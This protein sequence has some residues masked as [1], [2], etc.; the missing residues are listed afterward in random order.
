[1]LKKLIF[2][3]LGYT[4]IHSSVFAESRN[5]S[6]S[7]DLG[8]DEQNNTNSMLSVDMELGKS[9]HLF[10]GF[11]KSKIPSGSEII[12]NSLSF[13]GLSKKYSDDWKLTGML[14]FSGLRDA[15]TM[16]STSASIRYSQN[17][18]FIAL[19]PG[20]RIINLT[21]L[22][23]EHIIIS[24][25]ALGIKSGLYLGKHF[26]LSGSA[27]S[28]AYSHDVS[29]LARIDST[30]YFNETTLLLSSGL[31]KKSYN[32]E[33]GLDFQSFSIS[34]GKNKSISAIDNSSSNYVYTVLDYYISD[35]WGLS[36]LYGEYLDTPADQNNYI[37]LS[38]NYTF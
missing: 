27:Y 22:S 11:G 5:T 9:K 21:K 20:L 17:S 18:Y 26:R 31:L 13:V 7:I 35:A 33:T 24:S 6:I 32:V 12:E 36:V 14:E 4:L 15:F 28:Y 30:R 3:V 10:F 16:L 8:K 29:T 2:I 23:N 19:V 37:S 38:G 25:T 34:L 1:M